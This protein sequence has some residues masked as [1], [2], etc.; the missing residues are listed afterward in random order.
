[1]TTRAQVIG[2]DLVGDPLPTGADLISLVRVVH[3]HDDARA[4]AILSAARRALP[5]DGA[6]ILA[7]SMSDTPGA[8]PTGEASFGFYL[9]AMGS[10]RPRTCAELTAMLKRAGFGRVREVATRRPIMTRL[11]VACG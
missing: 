7:E 3:D 11:L 6:L 4:Q 9:L 5:P 1:L 8:E 10:G 2:G